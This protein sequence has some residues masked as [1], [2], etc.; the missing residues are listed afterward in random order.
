MCARYNLHSDPKLLVEQFGLEVGLPMPRF[1]ICPTQYVPLIRPATDRPGREV[2]SLRWGLIP[3]WADDPKIAARLINARAETAAD[4]PAFRSAF[5]RRRCLVPASGFYEWSGPKK[6]RQPHVF[7]FRDGRP[8]A[9]AGLWEE[10]QRDG[11]RIQSFT[12]LTTEA[13]EVLA[14]FHDRMPVIVH[15]DDYDLWMTGQPAEV[16]VLL[17]PYPADDLTTKPV[18]KL[19]PDPDAPA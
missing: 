11:E 14:P 18:P 15:R 13:N 7:E 17:R 6:S 16:S 1:N 5:K 3:S 10:W 9:F 12:I 8:F 4:K 19:T 2:A